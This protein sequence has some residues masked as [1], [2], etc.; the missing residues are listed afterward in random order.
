MA[1]L[2][3]TEAQAV[4][5]KVRRSYIK[6]YVELRNRYKE[7][8]I[9]SLVTV[10]ET[11]K[12]L[13]NASVSVRCLV[14]NKKV[15][16]AVVLNFERAGEVTF[17]AEVTEKGIGGWLLKVIEKVAREKKLNSIWAWVLSGNRIAQKAFE[18]NGYLK[19]KEIIRN[20][21]GREVNGIIFRKLISSYGFKQ[22]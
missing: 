3:L 12:W 8:L 22:K 7:L 21:G 14:L 4:D 10:E 16:G 13:D 20:Y 9:T 1:D 2:N 6:Q 11:V 18:K 15:I 5:L 17:F 19:E